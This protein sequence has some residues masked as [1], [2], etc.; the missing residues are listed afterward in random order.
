MRKRKDR[1]KKLQALKRE[2]GR[3]LIEQVRRQLALPMNR[4]TNF[5]RKRLPGGGSCL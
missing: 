2:S 1:N 4:R 5:L 3:N